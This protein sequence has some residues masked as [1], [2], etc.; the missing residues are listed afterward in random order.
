[1]LSNDGPWWT[2][3]SGRTL[4]LR[5]VNL[6]G[7]GKLPFQPYM[8]SH[9]RDGFFNDTAVSFVGRPFPLHEAD[10]HF[11]RLR[12]WGFNFLRFNT[13]W[14]AL[15]H[16][17]PGIYDYE[18]MDYV[19]QVLLKAKEYGFRVFID[20]HQD[21]WSRF[22]GGSGAPGWTF[23]VAGLDITKFKETHAAIVHNTYDE[24]SFPKM[25]W[26]TNYHKLAAATM[27]TLF[28]GGSI[29]A[30]NLMVTETDGRTVSI[31]D[32]L[33]DHYCNALAELAKRIKMTPGLEDDVVIGYDTLNEPSPGWIGARDL[34][35]LPE[36]QDLKK[37]YVP[38]PFQAMQLGMGFATDV[39]T[40]NMTW[41]GPAKSGTT[42]LDPKGVS[43]WLPASA[44]DKWPCV[45]AQHGVW[46]PATRRLLRKDYFTRHPVTGAPVDYL[47]DCWR[48]FVHRVTR[49]IRS[50]HE[51][52]FIFVEPP[53][54]I[55]PPVWDATNGDPTDRIAYAPHWYDGL[56]LM[57][58]HF[59]RWYNVDVIGYKRGQY[60]AVPFALR[61]GESG[62]REVFRE[63]IEAVRREG[64]FYLGQHPC[65]FG[66]IGLPYDLD[67]KASYKTGNYST[68]EWAMDANMRALEAN[69]V[70][71]TIWTYVADNNNTWGDGWNG[72]DLSIFCR[73]PPDSSD[74]RSLRST[75]IP[76]VESALLVRGA[77]PIAEDSHPP[78]ETEATFAALSD[79]SGDSV[80][81]INPPFAEDDSSLDL[82]GRAVPA[83][84]RPYPVLT[85]GTPAFLSFDMASSLFTYSFSHPGPG[86][87]SVILWA[88]E[89]RSVA[90]SQAYKFSKFLPR[91]R[92]PLTLQAA[93][94]DADDL[95]PPKRAS[96]EAAAASTHLNGSLNESLATEV[97]IFVPRMHYPSS[98]EV[99]V[100]VSE[101]RVRWGRNGQRLYWDCGCFGHDQPSRASFTG[102]ATVEHTIVMRRRRA[103]QPPLEDIA[104]RSMQA[105]AAK[106]ADEIQRLESRGRVCG[107][108]AIL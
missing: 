21:V 57:N 39:E 85:P 58:K 101:G 23:R 11:G 26:P 54:N 53:V 106:K 97:E 19:V 13:T 81:T 102:G 82:G 22:S 103:G 56:T 29:F 32:Y 37:G 79:Y 10:E 69:L 45:W 74:A 60:F 105:I 55:P 31:Q 40:W 46:D 4:L 98:D 78:S 17:G 91:P 5:G 9:V 76:S 63:Q 25:I 52:A 59:S 3:P 80:L 94:G 50:V 87:A 96:A 48:L 92:H 104:L 35:A 71:Y 89:P 68:Q 107:S 28:F 20:A 84:A 15:E 12:R 2:D 72:E 14:E 93:D 67:D 1:M 70:N 51:N 83:F 108:C 64:F 36:E 8:P 44:D 66:E 47:K 34:N 61:F 100:W 77:A 75:R 99:E 88:D 30:P 95:S 6:S 73:L 42:R 33:Q 16:G 7:S 18:Y 38:T 65:V 43:A 41:L 27:F 86:A 90:P 62:V 24:P 49:A